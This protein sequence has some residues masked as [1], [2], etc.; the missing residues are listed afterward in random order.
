MGQEINILKY[1]GIT[2]ENGYINKGAYLSG[3]APCHGGDN[4]TGFSFLYE[5]NIWA[6]WTHHC[7]E[8]Y[9][10]SLVGLI[11]AIK[12]VNTETAIETIKNI[13][14]S[15]PQD[16]IKVIKPRKSIDYWRLHLEQP[17]LPEYI[18][19]KYQ[20]PEAYCLE[21]GFNMKTVMSYGMGISTFGPLSWR[22]VVPVRN[23]EGHLVGLS[24]RL[25]NHKKGD[26]TQKWMHWPSSK[27]NEE[28]DKIKGFSK[29]LNL[30]NI[31]RVINYSKNTNDS[32]IILT[33]G[34]LD[35]LKFEMAGIH[36]AVAVLGDNICIGQIQIL[37]KCN[38]T[39]IILAFDN[40]VAGNKGMEKTA[41][42]L[43]KKLFR[44]YTIRAEEGGDW[45]KMDISK[46][47]EELNKKVKI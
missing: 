25:L 36:N 1:L 11:K 18:I 38:F 40:D 34:P 27:E 5:K 26:K 47:K 35:V 21:R 22:F 23:I 9:G 24:G 10:K 4:P 28:G 2:E 14:A 8:E 32:S 15:N 30:F 39:E 46:I 31:E 12:K 6:C 41:R 20:S 37:E 33:E 45:G 16:I 19:S 43:E 44:L 13:I 29:G 42:K 3:P 17:T 7:E